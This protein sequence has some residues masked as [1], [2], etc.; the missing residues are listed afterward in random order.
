MSPIEHREIEL[1][2]PHGRLT[3]RSFKTDDDYARCE[4]LQQAT[5]GE[6]FAEIASAT[7]MKITQKVG[8]VSAGAFDDTGELRGLVFGITGLRDGRPAHWSHILAVDSTLRGQGVGRHLKIFQRDFLLHLGVHHMYW[9]YDPLEAKNAHLNL[10]RLGAEPEEYHKDFYGDGSRNALHRGI[11]TD[12]FIVHWRL[13]GERTRSALKADVGPPAAWSEAPVVNVDPN[14][15]PDPAAPPPGSLPYLR[16]EVP[17]NIQTLKSEDLPQ[18]VA[19]RHASR[20]AFQR[21]MGHGYRVVG[22]LR[23]DGRTA[24]VLQAPE[25]THD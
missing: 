4:A 8:G 2:S 25:I 6:G 21:A 13:D 24:Y 12:R 23:W 14:G 3:L 19:W 15:T 1:P 5:W 9:T 17:A 20:H 18:A 11:G 10:T 16:I 7:M 22:F